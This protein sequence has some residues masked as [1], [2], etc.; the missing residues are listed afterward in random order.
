[1]KAIGVVG[2][3]N[4]GKTTLARA[5]AQELSNRGYRV[6][7]AKHASE[8]FDSL[9]KDT[10]VLG[11]VANP[12]AFV[13]PDQSGILWRGTVRLEDLLS[14][15]EADL[16]IVEG[17]K[18]RTA[19]PKIACLRGEPGDADLLDRQV[20]CAVGP[21][22][23]ELPDGVP[24]YQLERIDLIADLVERKAVSLP[25]PSRQGPGPKTRSRSDSR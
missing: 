19:F 10:A 1:M 7:A 9:G 8:R 23:E 13:S 20:I 5:L 11:E 2:Y 16:V 25:V 21:T 15:I 4:S 12:V 6:A 17:F 18:G 3:H 22:T 14:H 24:L